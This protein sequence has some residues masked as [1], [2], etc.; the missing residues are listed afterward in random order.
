MNFAKIMFNRFAFPACKNFGKEHLYIRHRLSR[1]ERKKH[2]DTDLDC[3]Y[4]FSFVSA[5]EDSQYL[6]CNLACASLVLSQ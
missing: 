1:G 6:N 3:I 4:V 2:G 5:S